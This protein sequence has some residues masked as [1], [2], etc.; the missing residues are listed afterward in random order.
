MST[1]FHPQTD[2]HTEVANRS[3]T[4]ILQACVRADQRDWVKCL[5]MVEYMINTSVTTSTGYSPF[6]L[7]GGHTP[8]MIRDLQ[9]LGNGV[10]GVAEFA[11]TAL[12][13]LMDAHNA[14]IVSWEFQIV[15]ANRAR[16]KDPLLKE[17]D[18]V[19]LSTKNLNASKGRARKL[20]PKFIGP[21]QIIECFPNESVYKLDLPDNLKKRQIHPSFH[22]SS[23]K[24]FIASSNESFPNQDHSDPYD[25]GA[26]ADAEYTVVEITS[27]RWKQGKHLEFEVLWD[28]GDVTW[29]S[30]DNC[31]N[32]SALDAYLELKGLNDPQVLSKPR[33][34]QCQHY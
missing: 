18:L 4:Q 17:G 15:Y 26:P 19:Y 23:L 10:P 13:H 31:Q 22:I 3:V 33:K 5:P 2:G 16:R 1:S 8:Q 28:A 24:P 9:K 20:I 12:R 21:Y 34:R 27:H 32:L 6:F 7:N 14:L 30:L 29:E 11:H 25:F